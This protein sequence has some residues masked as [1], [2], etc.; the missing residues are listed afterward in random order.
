MKISK[1]SFKRARRRNVYNRKPLGQ[2]DQVVWE[3]SVVDIFNQ[4]GFQKYFGFKGEAG[5]DNMRIFVTL[6]T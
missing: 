2:V 1:L 4:T 5:A 3:L 6:L